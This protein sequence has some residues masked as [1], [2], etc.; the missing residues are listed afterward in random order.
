MKLMIKH[1]SEL[2]LQ[3]LY[4][5]LRLRSEV[6][7]TEQHGCYLDP[8]GIDCSS[9]HIFLWDEAN[10]RAE[11]CLRL[12]PRPGASGTM[13]IGRLA[14]RSRRCGTG[15]R[16]MEQARILAR[17]QYQSTDLFLEGR[18][19]ARAFYEACGYR[20]SLPAGYPNEEDAPYFEFSRSI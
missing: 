1:F 13:Q 10:Q 15:S 16:L 2:T 9:V 14:V 5:I 20:A 4:E 19:S 17:D 6:F 7:I 12:F 3:E 18:S 11:A 8:D